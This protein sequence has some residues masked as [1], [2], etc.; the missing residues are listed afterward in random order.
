MTV[1]DPDRTAVERFCRELAPLVTSG[2]PGIVGY[3]SGRPIAAAGLRLLAGP[4]A[5]SL[6]ETNA[7]ASANRT[8]WQA[9]RI[10][11]H[12]PQR[13]DVGRREEQS[14]LNEAMDPAGETRTHP[15]A[16]TKG[17]DRTSE[18]SPTTRP[19]MLG[20]KLI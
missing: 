13:L 14:C 17:I 1:R 19:A 20:S 16:A 10:G 12:L 7:R 5:A 18:W 8:E 15:A 2:P 11:P 4:G 9:F 6:A 3:A